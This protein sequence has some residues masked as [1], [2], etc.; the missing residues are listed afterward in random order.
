MKIVLFQ[1]EGDSEPQPGL[2]TDRG[3]VGLGD[4]VP[5]GHTPQLTMQGLIDGFNG[6]RPTLERLA[7][8]HETLPLESVRL[9]APLPRPG[10]ILCST[11]VYRDQAEGEPRPLLMTLK[12]PDAVVGP[13]ESIVLPEAPEGWAFLPEAELGVVIKGPAKEVSQERWRDAVFGYTCVID[14]MGHFPPEPLGL[15]P[16]GRDYWLAKS[17]TLGPLGPCVVTADEIPDPDDLQIQ[18]WIN[19]ESR[20][21]YNTASGE[22][23][24]PRLLE[25]ATTVMTLYTGDVL[26]CGSSRAGLGPIQNGDTVDVEIDGIGRLSLTVSDPLKRSWKRALAEV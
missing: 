9:L 4:A 2:L 16:A 7:T 5:R 13:G 14:I 25:L 17:D 19:G 3:V 1:G 6:L 8:S 11:N 12:G 23:A 24:V 26:A 18:S 10:K 21:Q 20:Q 22:Y 15:V